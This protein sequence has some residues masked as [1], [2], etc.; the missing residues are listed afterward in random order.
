[1]RGKRLTVS[2]DDCA[3]EKHSDRAPASPGPRLGPGITLKRRPA[4]A[5]TPVQKSE[6]HLRGLTVEEAIERVD[7]FL[8]DAYLGSLSQPR[9]VHGVGSGRLKQAI[10]SFLS[11]H[12]HVESFTAAAADEGGAGVTIVRL[13][14]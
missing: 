5:A 6:I 10:W 9:L 11:G 7:K 12:P 13:K 1:V 2:R 3:S 4:L 14:P 8:D